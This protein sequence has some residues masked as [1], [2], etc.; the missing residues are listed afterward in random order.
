LLATVAQ[1]SQL[2]L[3]DHQLLTQV[4]V[5]VV[6]VVAQ[7]EQ[8]VLAAVEQEQLILQLAEQEQLI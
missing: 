2:Q 1:V 6:L 3:L 4:A 8:V 7:Q 5:A